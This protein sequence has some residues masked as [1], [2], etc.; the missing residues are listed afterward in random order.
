[1]LIKYTKE[2]KA[3]FENWKKTNRSIARKIEKLIE[4]I[5]QTLY[6]GLG[7]P[8]ALKYKYSGFWSRH[9]DKKNRLVYIILENDDLL[10]ID[11]LKVIINNKKEENS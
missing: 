10:V 11:S 7:E 8:E 9:I 5:K 6:T 2:A 1:M 4:D 3:D